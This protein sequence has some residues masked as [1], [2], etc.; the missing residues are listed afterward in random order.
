MR[1]AWI[2]ISL[3][4]IKR[5]IA[6]FQGIIPGQT[7]IMGVV[8]ANAYGHGATQVAVALRQ[9]GV[10]LFGVALVQEGMELREIGIEDPILVLGYTPEE[11]FSAA[12]S[13]GL[14][15]TMYDLSQAL[16]LD[17]IAGELNTLAKV[18]IK[19]DTGMGRIGLQP[20]KSSV[21]TIVQ[22]ASLKNITIEG[23]FSHLAW[24]DNDK[25]KFSEIQFARFQRFI[26]DLSQAGVEIPLKHIANSAATINFPHMHLD[27][28][29]IGISL[30]GLYP[31]PQMAIEPRIKLYPAME[32]K[33]RLVRVKELPK[34][35]PISYGCTFVT[36]SRTVIGTVPMGYADGLPRLLSNK[37]EV[38]IRGQR[39]PIVGRVCMDQFMVDVTK[40]PGATV[41]D[42]VVIC[43]RQGQ[44]TIDADEIAHNAG[45][46]SY[47]IVTRMSPRMPRVYIK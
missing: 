8:K 22:I 15:L 11:D 10:K 35:A 31:D 38:L 36:P 5:N 9:A 7:Q 37:G 26:D 33:A 25:S 41:G 28:V 44:Q 42:E 13:H 1:P 32:I 6:S 21:Q 24:A 17:R 16:S 14:T 29:R 30:Y 45:T 3:P 19:I 34:G 12:L 39:C 43:G 27:L 4:A 18:H 40:V 47:E 20:Q 23:I 46:I 2:E